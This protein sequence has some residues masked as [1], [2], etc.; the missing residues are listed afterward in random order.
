[1]FKHVCPRTGHVRTFKNGRAAKRWVR[2]QEEKF[3]P[4]QV[5]SMPTGQIGQA[6][7]V[8]RSRTGN[9]KLGKVKD[10][11]NLFSRK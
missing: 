9:P 2:E 3:T 8:T 10:R 11:H 4:E 5:P 1:M 6:R 7:S